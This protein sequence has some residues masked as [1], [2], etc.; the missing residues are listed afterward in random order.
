MLVIPEGPARRELNEARFP[1]HMYHMDHSI[2]SEG[3]NTTNQWVPRGWY[4][5][6]WTVVLQ[7]KAHS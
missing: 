4:Y 3:T 2:E 5:C 7:R 1:Q 6:R